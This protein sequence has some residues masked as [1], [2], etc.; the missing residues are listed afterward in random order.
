MDAITVQEQLQTHVEML[1]LRHT[2]HAHNFGLS[3]AIYH[4]NHWTKGPNQ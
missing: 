2:K 1:E 3:G 4:N